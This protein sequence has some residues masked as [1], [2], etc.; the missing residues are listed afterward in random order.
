MYLEN[1]V[2][3]FWQTGVLPY[4]LS[5]EW[6]DKSLFTNLMRHCFPVGLYEICN[7]QSTLDLGG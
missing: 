4:F 7:R 3:N 1:E 5:T 2:D 6:G